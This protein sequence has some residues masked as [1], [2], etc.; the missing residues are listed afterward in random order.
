MKGEGLNLK[1][2]AMATLTQIVTAIDDVLQ[3]P[4]YTEGKITAKINAALQTVAAGIRMPN[5]EISPPLPDLYAYG[6]VNTSITLPYVSLPA[7]YQRHVF[8]VY[9]S[10]FTSV[11]I[12]GGGGYYSFALFLKQI[13]NPSLAEVGSIYRACVKGTKL[14]Y[15]GIPAAS[16]TLGV[17]YYRKPATLALDGDIPE[18]IPEHLQ[19]ALIKHYVCK[20]YMG[21]KIE[22]GQDNTGIGTKYHTAKFFEVMTNLCDAIGIDGEPQYYGEGGFEDAGACDG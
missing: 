22:D 8:N 6:T 19:T 4:A 1:G 5:G 12:P 11:S 18:G 16:T 10:S 9:D 15:Q 17:H 21:E 20:E 7:D 14:Y 3:D 2:W 13:S